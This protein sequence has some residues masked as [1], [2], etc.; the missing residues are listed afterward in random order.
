MHRG[1]G[2]KVSRDDL[3]V[4]LCAH[5]PGNVLN[6]KRGQKEMAKIERAS[7]YIGHR[8]KPPEQREGMVSS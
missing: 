4:C 6:G 8:D 3:Y 5:P 7:G 2:D 1:G